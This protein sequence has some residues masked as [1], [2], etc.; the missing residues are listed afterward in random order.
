MERESSESARYC[1]PGAAII[2]CDKV[3]VICAVDPSSGQCANV[4]STLLS[5]TAFSTV[6]V[7]L[8][9]SAGYG[10]SGTPTASQL[11]AY[12][13]VV[14]LSFWG[15]EDPVLLGDRLAAYH[16]QG[17][18]VV[19]T[20]ATNLYGGIGPTMLEG[21]YAAPGNGYALLNYAAAQGGYKSPSGSLGDV[22]EPL[23]PLMA[24]VTSLSAEV[25]LHGAAPPIAGRSV[26]V[27]RWRG[28]GNEPLVLR[29]TRGNRTLVELN[30]WPV[31]GGWTGDGA[32]L[33]RNAV[34]YSRCILR[35]T[36]GAGD[37]GGI[38]FPP[39][40]FSTSLCLSPYSLPPTHPPSLFF[41]LLFLSLRLSPCELVC[42]IVGAVIIIIIIPPPFLPLYVVCYK[43]ARFI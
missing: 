30:F 28:G 4:R 17:G 15:F 12:H 9:M 7:F 25:A 33:L 32:A 27:A 34:K 23:S 40:S 24:G 29:G 11:A 18:G 10:G 31:S 14:V 13:A 36:A 19:L 3:L 2:S 6:D 8:A 35:G 42:C 1:D 41:T 22:L 5:T 43:P 21:A 20:F 39:L 26:V 38:A 37:G 16:D